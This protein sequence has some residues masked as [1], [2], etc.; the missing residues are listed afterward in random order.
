MHANTHT[1]SHTQTRT[2]THTRTH[3]ARV[4][5][6]CGVAGLVHLPCK[7]SPISSVSRPQRAGLT[8]TVVLSPRGSHLLAPP[9]RRGALAPACYGPG[10]RGP[11]AWDRAAGRAG[12]GQP[13][14]RNKPRAGQVL[15]TKYVCLPRAR[16]SSTLCP[17]PPRRDPREPN[18]T[19]GSC[20]RW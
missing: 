15:R 6:R 18:C 17:F 11:A 9:L 16:R 1:R 4:G 2:H 3:D 19:P 7:I 13:R 10:E 14:C 12:S 8:A 20:M 5:I